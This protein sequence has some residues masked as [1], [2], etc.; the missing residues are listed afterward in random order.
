MPSAQAGLDTE[1]VSVDAI[2]KAAWLLKMRGAKAEQPLQ[3]FWDF[4][5]VDVHWDNA[6]NN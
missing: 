6:N 4:G 1:A 2:S 3:G 5:R